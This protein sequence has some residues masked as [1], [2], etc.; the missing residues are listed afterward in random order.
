MIAGGEVYADKRICN[1]FIIVCLT[2]YI[3]RPSLR[4]RNGEYDR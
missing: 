2:V 4:I 1:L 3:K